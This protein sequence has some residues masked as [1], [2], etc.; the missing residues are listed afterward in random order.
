MM[1]S[2]GN[3]MSSRKA[4]QEL[5]VNLPDLRNAKNLR[6]QA[7][8]SIVCSKLIGMNNQDLRSRN[9]SAGVT[10]RRVGHVACHK[11]CDAEE[12]SFAKEGQANKE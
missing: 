1:M 10:G 11:M 3:S 5:Q 8:Q 4:A 7:A 12:T 6:Q 9:R 2:H